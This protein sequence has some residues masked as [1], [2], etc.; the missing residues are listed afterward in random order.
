MKRLSSTCHLEL[1]KL[2]ELTSSQ[3]TFTPFFRL[4]LTIYEKGTPWLT[5]SR[6][7]LDYCFLPFWVRETNYEKGPHGA[8]FFRLFFKL[9][10]YEKDTELFFC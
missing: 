6:G 4:R 8:L 10:K 3:Y 1:I 7:S 9:S 2:N 5:W